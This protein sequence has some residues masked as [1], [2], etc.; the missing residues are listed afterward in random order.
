[1]EAP[2]VFF[3][4]FG[5]SCCCCRLATAF[6]GN[7]VAMGSLKRPKSA[8]K[9][10]NRSGGVISDV[11]I[12][13]RLVFS[14][15]VKSASGVARARSSSLISPSK[16]VSHSKD[17]LTIVFN[18]F[19][20]IPSVRRYNEGPTASSTDLRKASPSFGNDVSTIVDSE[21]VISVVCVCLCPTV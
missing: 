13:L 19:L 14:S 9:V 7:G 3:F 2:D 8:D 5:W 17:S 18:S 4:L 16:A 21:Q 15:F 11:V 10:K 20:G 6:G 1:M 12:R